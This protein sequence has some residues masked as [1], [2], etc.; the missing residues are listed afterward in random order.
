[1]SFFFNI[2]ISG[3]LTP[4]FKFPFVNPEDKS[5]VEMTWVNK[6]REARIMKESREFPG[7][8]LYQRPLETPVFVHESRF[9]EDDVDGLFEPDLEVT[10][11]DAHKRAVADA[12]ANRFTHKIKPRLEHTLVA[13]SQS[14]LH[15]IRTPGLD[16]YLDNFSRMHLRWED[17]YYGW[18]RN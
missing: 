16:S 1:M 6:W 10:S 2:R 18:S 7:Y 15:R 8:I 5:V 14:Q 3:Y 12:R 13:L 11:L 9:L 4:D 17:A